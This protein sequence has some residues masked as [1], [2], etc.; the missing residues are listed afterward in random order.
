M[1]RFELVQAHPF[2]LN[3]E[4]SSR[5][6]YFAGAVP[7]CNFCNV[8]MYRFLFCLPPGWRRGC[9]RSR[10]QFLWIKGK[11]G[12]GKSTMMQSV[13]HQAPKDFRTSII[14]AHFFNARGHIMAKSTQGM[15]RS[16]LH[17]IF[18]KLALCINHSKETY[19][20]ECCV[21]LFLPDPNVKEATVEFAL[22]AHLSF[23]FSF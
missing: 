18:S 17:Q 11:P 14:A 8:Y 12:A 5:L 2:V 7:A 21:T 6:C 15:Y 23:C 16:L 19:Y 13:F 22:D 10:R 4:D 20:V 3:E 9:R 1:L